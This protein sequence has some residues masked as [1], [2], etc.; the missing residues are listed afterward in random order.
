MDKKIKDY[1]KKYV[2]KNLKIEFDTYKI[3]KIYNVFLTLTNRNVIITV[4]SLEGNVYFK[5]SLGGYGVA[6]YTR[7][8][9]HLNYQFGLYIGSTIRKDFPGYYHLIVRGWAAREKAVIRA[10]FK[11]GLKIVTMSNKTPIAFNGCRKIH[12]RRK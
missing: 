12:K 11:G 9:Y 1:I 2:K 3:A 8:A 5:Q 7:K 10:M 6:G 4:T